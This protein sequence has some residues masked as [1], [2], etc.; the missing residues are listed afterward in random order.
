MLPTFSAFQVR[1]RH[2][3]VQF[4]TSSGSAA[5]KS[6]L[7][8]R[9]IF[10]NLFLEFNAAAANFFLYFK[11]AGQFCSSWSFFTGGITNPPT[12]TGELIFDSVEGNRNESDSGRSVLDVSGRV[13]LIQ[14]DELFFN[15]LRI[16]QGQGPLAIVRILP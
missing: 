15:Y 8:Y 13:V 12:I 4:F 14:Q 11:V 5:S 2:T 6:L 16:V 7:N 9:S 3:R 10:Q 1:L